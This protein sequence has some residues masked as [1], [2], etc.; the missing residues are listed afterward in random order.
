MARYVTLCEGG[1]QA[2][3][4]PS[5]HFSTSYGDYSFTVHGPIVRNGLPHHLWS[6]DIVDHFHE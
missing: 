5:R 2:L 4:T 6:T 1:K 3:V